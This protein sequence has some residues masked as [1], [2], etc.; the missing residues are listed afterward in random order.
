MWFVVKHLS[1]NQYPL[2]RWH[3]HSCVLNCSATREPPDHQA[4]LKGFRT[5]RTRISDANNPIAHIWCG[6]EV[7]VISFQETS[8]GQTRGST[9]SRWPGS[10]G[11]SVMWWS[12]RVSTNLE[13]SL[14]TPRKGKSDPCTTSGLTGQNRNKLNTHA[15]T[16]SSVCRAAVGSQGWN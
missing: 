4:F 9:W 15:V 2:R 3:I 10:M 11:P 14:C 12:P 7:F 8:T 16:L 5:F 13:P 1:N 6:Y